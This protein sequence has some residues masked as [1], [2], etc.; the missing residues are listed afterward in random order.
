MTFLTPLEMFLR[1]EEQMPE[2]NFLLQP[3][4]GEYHAYTWREVGDQARRIA[5]Y[6]ESLRLAPFTKIGILSNNC[7]HWV[8]TDLAIMMAKHISVP[9][10]P[11]MSKSSLS[12]IIDHSDLELLFVGKLDDR[13]KLLG[14]IPSDLPC[15]SFPFYGPAKFGIEWDQIVKEF[16]PLSG[17]ITVD[18]STPA[19]IMYTSGTGHSPKGAMHDYYNLTFVSDHY[20]RLLGIQPRDR[21]ISHLPMAQMA[22]RILIELQ[23]IYCGASITFLEFSQD[24]FPSLREAKPTLF[25]S[26]PHYWEQ[27]KERIQAKAGFLNVAMSIPVIGGVARRAILKKIGL[28]KTKTFLTG[29]APMDPVLKKWFGKL[30]IHFQ[31]IYAM[32]ENTCYG[33]GTL[34]ASAP[35]DSVGQALPE[36]EVELSKTG[37]VLIRHEGMMRGYYKEPELTLQAF[38]SQG[39]LKTGDRGR[40]DEQGNLHL[41]G[42]IDE[43]MTTEEGVIHCNEIERKVSQ[44]DLI[45][46]VCLV[47]DGPSRPVAMTVLLPESREKPRE[48]LNKELEKI[49]QKVNSKLSPLEQMAK[50]VV[51]REPMTVEN[52]LLTPTM[53]I[54]RGAV[55]KVMESHKQEWKDDDAHV[56]WLE[57]TGNT[58]S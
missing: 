5:A 4:E 33:L 38:T 58:G 42:R 28:H 53:K 2:E 40:F 15:V 41:L 3:V 47:G 31:E 55:E 29:G 14:A 1:W 19:T 18:A 45:D 13:D 50:M 16:D 22:E 54:K 23:A 49:F 21:L 34:E 11:N 12:R 27:I 6:L 25:G 51:M 43:E 39:F 9:L 8:I 32:T 37:E 46:Q 24:F 48:S 7:A 44:H 17:S 57:Q 36:V 30:G 52:G 10:F 20:R 56:I 26:L 35:I